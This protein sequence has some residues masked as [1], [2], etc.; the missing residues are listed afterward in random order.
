MTGATCV[1]LCQSQA[2]C[3]EGKAISSEKLTL[4]AAFRVTM[5]GLHALY[6]DRM[7]ESAALKK[8]RLS[9]LCHVDRLWKQIINLYPRLNEEPDCSLALT[10][11]RRKT[12]E[13][14]PKLPVTDPSKIIQLFESALP[15][16]DILATADPS[17]CG[18]YV[19]ANWLDFQI[20]VNDSPMPTYDGAMQLTEI[21]N[22]TIIYV[23][24]APGYKVLHV[25]PSVR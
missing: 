1:I 24:S 8:L 4:Q 14:V 11:Q 2:G 22:G 3:Y 18:W 7:F 10:A 12:F 21:N 25:S 5:L 16:S 23:L 20:S 6:G 15:P 13:P 19:V 9:H 17:S